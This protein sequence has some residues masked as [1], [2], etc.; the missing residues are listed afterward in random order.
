M[1]TFIHTAD[2]QLGKPF[3]GIR[4]VTKRSLVQ[5]E[6]IEAIRRIRAAVVERRAAFVLVAGDLFDSPTPT[7]TVVAQALGVIGE[8]PVPV[9]AIPGN[10]D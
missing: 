8:M 3:A 7:R 9:Y 6:R 2:W 5:Q 1:T 4:D 10:H